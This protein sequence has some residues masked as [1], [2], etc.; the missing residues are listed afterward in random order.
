MSSFSGSRPFIWSQYITRLV[1]PSGAFLS[2]CVRVQSNT[3]IKLYVTHF[4][5]YLAQRRMFSQYTSSS[6]STLLRPSLMSSCTGMLSTTSNTRPWASHWAFILAKLSSGHTS[7]GFTSYTAETMLC[8]PGI[9]EMYSR[10]MGSDSP[11][12]RNDIFIEKTS[13]FVFDTLGCAKPQN[14]AF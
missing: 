11:Y 3:G 2:S 8:M 14:A 9:C 5:P 13:R 7:P 10:E 12:Q 6:S 1:E 4:T